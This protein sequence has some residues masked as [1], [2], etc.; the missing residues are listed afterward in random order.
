MFLVCVPLVVGKCRYRQRHEEQSKRVEELCVEKHRKDSIFRDLENAPPQKMSPRIQ[1]EDEMVTEPLPPAQE[2]GRAA[3]AWQ[4]D[5]AL[6]HADEAHQEKGNSDEDG[7]KAERD[8]IRAAVLQPPLP[9]PAGSPPCGGVPVE[10]FSNLGM[11]LQPQRISEP[12]NGACKSVPVASE[13]PPWKQTLQSMHEMQA[14]L[15]LPELPQPMYGQQDPRALRAAASSHLRYHPPRQVPPELGSYCRRLGACIAGLEQDFGFALPPPP[16]AL[17]EQDWSRR[18]T[19]M[20]EAG[21]LSPR[22]S[23]ASGSMTESW[24][25]QQ[26]EAVPEA[27]GIEA[28]EALADRIAQTSAM[29]RSAAQVQGVL[30]DMCGNIGIVASGLPCSCPSGYAQWEALPSTLPPG[31]RNAES[32]DAESSLGDGLH[33]MALPHEVHNLQEAAAFERSALEAIIKKRGREG[34]EAD[35]LR[36]H[37]KGSACT[38]KTSRSTSSTQ[39]GHW[40]RSLEASTLSPQRTP[41]AERYEAFA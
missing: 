40:D 19:D 21:S 7:D 11:P 18:N 39:E 23:Q 10:D 14:G 31:W 30:C 27:S 4:Q 36:S 15:T 12:E 2:A 16:V 5:S 28:L 33:P 29:M 41:Q 17:A 32:E 26:E 37:L 25:E 34:Q 1:E 20:V 22:T 13:L 35:H 6:Q 24:E 8:L 3:Q 9:P 38:W